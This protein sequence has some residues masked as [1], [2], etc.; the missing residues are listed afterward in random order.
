MPFRPAD[1]RPGHQGP[2]RWRHPRPDETER[3]NAI[4][5]WSTFGPHAIGYERFVA[6]SS[7]T[8][9]A[10]GARAILQEQARV[11]NPDK[12]A[13]AGGRHEG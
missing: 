2:E 3:R 10:Q 1:P 7:G 13:M 6:V 11:Q 4:R 8:S 9:F 5:P 12:T